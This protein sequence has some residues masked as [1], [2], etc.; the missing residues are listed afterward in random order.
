MYF[1]GVFTVSSFLESLSHAVIQVHSEFLSLS[2]LLLCLKND[3]KLII[4]E[5]SL[6]CEI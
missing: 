5:I 2:N 3:K 1:G 4:P 6:L